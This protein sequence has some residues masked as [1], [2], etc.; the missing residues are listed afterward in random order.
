MEGVGV[1]RFW[2]IQFEHHHGCVDQVAYTTSRRLQAA[3]PQFQISRPIVASDPIF[4]MHS[5][6]GS[7]GRPS[8]SAITLECSAT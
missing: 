8:L 6:K 7:S 4:V 1:Q 3:S 2:L 5:S